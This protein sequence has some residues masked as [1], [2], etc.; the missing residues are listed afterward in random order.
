MSAKAEQRARRAAAMIGALVVALVATP[1]LAAV[2][3][4]PQPA[5]APPASGEPTETPDDETA[6]EKANLES[7]EEDAPAE[8]ATTPS[9][10]PAPIP[11]VAPA[12]APAIGPAPAPDPDLQRRRKT[13]SG[14]AGAGAAFLGIG[15]AA[16]VFLALPAWIA[17]EVAQQRAE[18]EPILVSENELYDRAE[19]R[20][21][22]AR[23]SFWSGLGGVV[24]GGTMLGIGLGTKA[25]LER[26][27]SAPRPQVRLHLLPAL[28]RTHAGATLTLRY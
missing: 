21:R 20:R 6:E 14:V 7:W 5:A 24:V 22:F 9:P 10:A 16:W 19:R 15:G 28:G 11:T 3:R 4:G 27:M 2:Q 13:A 1:A 12:P 26:E 23:I 8:P 18:D 17:A 25:K